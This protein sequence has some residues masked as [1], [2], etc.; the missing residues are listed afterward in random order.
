[1]K[2]VGFEKKWE[3]KAKKWYIDSFYGRQLNRTSG[4]FRNEILKKIKNSVNLIDK[5]ELL[6][7]YFKAN[8]HKL[9]IYK[10]EKQRNKQ[11]ATR[12]GISVAT[13]AIA[14]GTLTHYSNKNLDREMPAIEKENENYKEDTQIKEENVENNTE[15][16]EENEQENETQ[17]YE[18]FF[19]EIKK[20]NDDEERDDVIT[21][22][23]KDRMVEAY[24][25]KHEEKI[26]SNQLEYNNLDEFVLKNKDQFGNDISYERVLQTQ[27]ITAGKNQEIDKLKGGLY[28][29]ILKGEKV[30]VYD[31][32][33]QE[34]IDKEVKQK[35]EFFKETIPIAKEAAS[36]K[37][38]YRY[39][40][41]DNDI[42]KGEN[43][44][45]SVVENFI[46]NEKEQVEILRENEEE[47]GN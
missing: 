10:I 3:N 27:V 5:E 32:N 39:A 46:E 2:F 33:G 4:V 29:F 6:N 31:C 23:T 47:K 37:V 9:K 26:S 1:M 44:Y 20:I 8:P 14:T 13:F 24:N 43:H 16:I 21:K 7:N 15:T 45:K 19:E 25:L 12:V 30:A 18:D 35:N 38:L 34:I 42:K 41:N 17:K 28:E 36:L 40:H 11:I 22:F